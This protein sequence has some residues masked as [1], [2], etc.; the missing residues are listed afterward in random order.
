MRALPLTFHSERVWSVRIQTVSVRQGPR[1]L[2]PFLF[3]RRAAR[4]R[5]VM[6]NMILSWLTLRC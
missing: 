1:P 5:V 4:V 6:A 2:S 3:L